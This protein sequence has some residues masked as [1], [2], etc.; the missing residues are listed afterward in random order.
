[1]T[2]LR[3]L[4]DGVSLERDPEK[5]PQCRPD[6]G[7]AGRWL[8]QAEQVAGAL[9]SMAW[10]AHQRGIDVAPLREL[11]DRFGDLEAV[12]YDQMWP[13]KSVTD[14]DHETVEG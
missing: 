13:D 4:D 12:L 9:C 10:I 2:G 8:D 5:E 11:A 7:T 6:A 1:M 3:R 14:G